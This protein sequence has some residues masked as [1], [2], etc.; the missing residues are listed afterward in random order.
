MMIMKIMMCLTDDDYE[1][2]DVS[3]LGKAYGGVVEHDID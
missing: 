3:D 2:N 1:D